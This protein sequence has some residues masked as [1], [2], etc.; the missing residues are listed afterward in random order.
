MIPAGLLVTVPVPVPDLLT[1]SANMVT[2]VLK[3]AVTDLA[4]LMVTEQVP[5]PVQAPLHP[6]KVEP[7]A[8]AAL[9]VTTEP[10]LKLAAQVPGQLMP[11]G[12]LLT[13]PAPVPAKLTVNGKVAVLNVAVT[14]WAAFIVTLHAPVP[15]QAPVQPAKVDPEPA[16]AV[17]VTTVPLLKLLAHVPGQ[18]I[19]AGLLVTEPVPVPARLAVNAKVTA[20]VLKVAVTAFA[21]LM[22]TEQAPVPVQ[23]PLHPAK[24]EPEAAAAVSVTTV[25]LLKEALQVPGQLIPAGLLVTV[26]APVPAVVSDSVNELVLLLFKFSVSIAKSVQAPAQLVRLMVTD[27]IFVP[28]W[29]TIPM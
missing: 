29:S 9:R 24:V 15:M 26:P 7:D 25:P 6:A 8:P 5:V 19:P 4:A 11:A 1:A 28:V 22:V 3:V 18:L 10:L 17:S 21:A 16:A 2:D 20:F 27:V 13:E 12:L 23:P 14:D